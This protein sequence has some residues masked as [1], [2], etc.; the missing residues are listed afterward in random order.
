MNSKKIKILIIVIIVIIVIIR[1]VMVL[2]DSDKK[3]N[4]NKTTSENQG[5]VEEKEI[6]I[7]DFEVEGINEEVDNQIDY[8]TFFILSSC[9]SNYATDGEDKYITAIVDAQ[10]L[11]KDQVESYGVYAIAMDFSYNFKKE[12][13]FI[14][15]LDRVNYTFSVE[16][17]EQKYS[18]LK[19]IPVNKLEKVEKEEYNEFDYE[20]INKE[21]VATKFFEHLK[22]LILSKPDIAYEKL[23]KNYRN[24]R[25]GSYEYFEQYVNNNRERISNIKP[26]KYKASEDG[27]I[28]TVRDQE[29]NGY[30]FKVNG[31]M[32]YTA[33]IDNY[34]VLFDDDIERYY[35]KLDEEQ[36]VEY[37]ITRWFK[38]LSSKDFKYAYEFLDEEFRK[39]NYPD[40]NNF[41]NYISQIYNSKNS[42]TLHD[43]KEEGNVFV[44]EVVITNEDD[45]FL[46]KYM[47]II[48][49]LDEN[50]D[51]TMSFELE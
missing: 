11:I 48:I 10:R 24:K 33:K 5:K 6:D 9:V 31:T 49:R 12:C 36:Q 15:N 21:Y 26:N 50:T 22:R 42:F 4:Y 51:F 46:N 14:V 25:F 40:V 2:L 1:L 8:Q 16:E 7:D 29:G 3:K 39:Q 13:Y 17:L 34:I 23:D 37:N 30:E 28:I 19:D 43:I 32:E 47:N 35:A 45:E 20:I 41:A 38:M 27:K 18:N 44:A